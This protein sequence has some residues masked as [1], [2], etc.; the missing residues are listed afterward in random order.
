MHIQLSM[1]KVQAEI[2]VYKIWNFGRRQEVQ[3]LDNSIAFKYSCFKINCWDKKW[4]TCDCF[5][6]PLHTLT[7]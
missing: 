7:A 5:T 4:A 6:Y 3:D 2:M 1:K